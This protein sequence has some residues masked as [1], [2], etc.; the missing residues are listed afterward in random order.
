LTLA[1]YN[2]RAQENL[3]F[4]KYGIGFSASLSRP[5]ADTKKADQTQSYAITANYF[6]TPYVPIGLEFQLGTLSGGG[7]TANL[8][9]YGRI[10]KNDYKAILLHMD[11]QLGELISYRRSG[12]LDILKNFYAG[13][14]VGVISNSMTDIQRT[15]LILQNGAIGA[16]HGLEGEDN[17]LNLVIPIRFGYEFKIYNIYGQP[18]IR[19]DI[20]YQHNVTFSEGLDGYNDSQL[21]FKNNAYDQYGQITIGLKLNFA[22]QDTY[23]KEI[24]RS[25]H[26]Y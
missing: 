1:F 20:G 19:L 24:R 11:V 3:N 22:G 21:K 9:A 23:D 16:T 13:S 7:R 8:D 14:G 15:N 5:Y 12:I 10:Y 25:K 17:S 18:N 26:E 2:G 6:Y 4:A